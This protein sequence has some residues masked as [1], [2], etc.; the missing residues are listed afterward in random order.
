MK[1]LIIYYS[2]TGKTKQW[3][4]Q[5]A[6]ETDAELVEVKELKDRSKFNAY[7]FGS[8]SARKQKNPSIQPISV[9]FSQY[10]KILIAGPIWAGFPAP[11]INA[12]IELL[13]AEKQ[14]AL[15]FTSGGGSSGSS[16][17]KTEA[18]IRRKGCTVG[19]YQDVRANDIKSLHPNA[20]S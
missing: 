19:A 14:V 13:P 5:T 15:V 11:A 18:L 2:Y 16:R 12:I 7:V 4:Q 8:L 17:E 20:A 9:D 10:E 1:Q 3:A 6:K